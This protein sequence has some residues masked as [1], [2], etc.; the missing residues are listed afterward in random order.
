MNWGNKM[1]KVALF[2]AG[3]MGQIHGGNL[4]QQSGIE[5]AYVYDLDAAAA[6]K[7]A[8][9]FGTEAATSID[10]VFNDSSVQAIVVASPT[11]THSDLILRAA[12]SGKAVFCEKPVDLSLERAKNCLEAVRNAKIVCMI[13]FQRRFDPTFVAAFE[14]IKSGEIGKVEQIIVTSRDP[15]PP[16]IDYIKS[17]GGIFRDMLIHDFDI[18]QWLSGEGEA[19]WVFATGATLI[20]PAIAEAGDIDTTAVTIKM[21][22]GILC[23][24]NTTRRAAYGYDQRF[25]AN[26]SKG[27]VQAGNL[28]KHEATILGRNAVQTSVPEPFFL[29]RY[30]DAYR[31]EMAHFA[32]VLRGEEKC[33]NPIEHGV[34]AQALADAA[35]RSYQQGT[36]LAV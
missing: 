12:Q 33:R 20:D 21:K 15:G 1:I 16:P 4:A 11:T 14:A 24:I 27:A 3:R 9:R 35:A 26:G 28:R 18:C 6:A 23:Q 32:A 17:S 5:F 19:E 13:G 34:A 10:Q 7:L 25:E 2:G 36:K 30:A 29:E 22:S 31:L 8:A